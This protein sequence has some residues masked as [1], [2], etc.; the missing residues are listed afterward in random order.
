MRFI[1]LQV[2]LLSLFL[3]V[4]NTPAQK[5]EITISFN[6]Q[7][8]DALLDAVFQYAA[9]PEFPLAQT[10][11][12]RPAPS[13][14]LLANSLAP[15]GACSESIKLLRENYGRRTSVRF[16]D[17]R[18]TAPIAFSG[19]YNPPLI[20]CVP[21]VGV[22]DTNVDLEFDE[23]GQRL[24]ARARVND[25]ALNGTGGIG[26]GLV[27][28]MVQGTIDKKINPIEIV[29]TD[30]VSFIIPLQNSNSVRMR[31]TGFAHEIVN[32]QLIIRIMYEFEK[33]R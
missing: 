30:K 10:K 27:T 19:N 23:R 21:F 11:T 13:P 3:F 16:R 1:K 24:L 18:I 5:T 32:G 22:A 29:K 4:S 9:P 31:A 20:G 7:F 28:R 12:G 2:L 14:A 8:F 15:A 6:E 26:G 25:V 17:G 33:A